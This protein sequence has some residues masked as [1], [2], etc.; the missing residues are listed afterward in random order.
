MKAAKQNHAVAQYNIGYMYENGDAGS[1]D[2]IKAR[3]WFEKSA[4]NGNVK[5]KEKLKKLL[6]RD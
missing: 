6:L 5:A 4:A 2:L 3:Q 1:S